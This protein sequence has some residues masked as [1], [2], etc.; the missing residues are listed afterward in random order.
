MK[1][2]AELGLFVFI[3]RCRRVDLRYH[4]RDLAIDTF[5]FPDAVND[6]VTIRTA[7]RRADRSAVKSLR[8]AIVVTRGTRL[9]RRRN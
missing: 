1:M 3:A 6:R 4:L 2:A 7:V 8:V 9:N 5:P